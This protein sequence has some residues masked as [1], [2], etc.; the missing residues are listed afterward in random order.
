MQPCERD[1]VGDGVASCALGDP[2]IRF[3]RLA[4]TQHDAHC[5]R[6]FAKQKST[7]FGGKELKQSLEQ[8]ACNAA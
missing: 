2:C 3:E 1:C 5:A 8:S 7:W 4:E 6:L